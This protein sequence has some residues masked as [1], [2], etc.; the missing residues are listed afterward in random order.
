VPAISFRLD[1]TRGTQQNPEISLSGE[2]VKDLCEVIGRVFSRQISSDL[3]VL[4]A[5]H[6]MHRMRSLQ[7]QLQLDTMISLENVLERK[8]RL[9]RR[10]KLELAVNLA[11]ASMQLYG[12]VWLK[13]QWGDEDVYFLQDIIEE[14]DI[15]GKTVYT[16]ASA[17]K[18]DGLLQVP[19]VCR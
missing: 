9:Q 4:A 6:S 16:S 1:E 8:N 15:S 17:E 11:S 19:A 12:T 3:G 2:T 7:P 13:K 10:E 5:K 14:V 18:A